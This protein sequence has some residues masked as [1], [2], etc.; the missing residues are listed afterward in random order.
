MKRFF[1]VGSFVVIVASQSGC[2]SL[3]V[4][5]IPVG[6]SKPRLQVY[7]G[8]RFWFE[9]FPPDS[10]TLDII[11]IVLAMFV[12]VPLCFILDTLTLPITIPMELSR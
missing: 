1:L 3:L 11:V 12:D 5:L 9:G 10:S 2:A 6:H 8:V 4:N 7:G